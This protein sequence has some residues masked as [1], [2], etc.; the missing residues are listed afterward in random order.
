LYG[1]NAL[2]GSIHILTYSPSEL[3]NRT[4][5]KAEAGN[6]DS[7]GALVQHSQA[8]DF[9]SFS[10]EAR[11]WKSDGYSSERDRTGTALLGQSTPQELQAARVKASFLDDKLILSAETSRFERGY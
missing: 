11:N 7:Y 8:T 6:N 1:T 5:V 10:V 4:Q 3:G 9:G 2:S